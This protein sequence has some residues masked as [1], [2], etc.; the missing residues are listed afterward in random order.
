MNQTQLLVEPFFNETVCYR[1]AI[2][3][4]PKMNASNPSEAFLHTLDLFNGFGGFLLTTF[5]GT[6]RYISQGWN[7]TVELWSS[8]AMHEMTSSMSVKVTTEFYI[9]RQEN[10]SLTQGS[11]LCLRILKVQVQIS[12]NARGVVT[13][14][15]MTTNTVFEQYDEFPKMSL[16]TPPKNVK[17]IDF[18]KSSSAANG[19]AANGSGA[20]SDPWLS[21]L[22]VQHHQAKPKVA[23]R[24][25]QP[26][27]NVSEIARLNKANLGWSAGVNEVFQ[28][29]LA[30]LRDA[31]ALCG[32]VVLPGALSL[33]R[34]KARLI[35]SA[36]IP[37]SFD[38][39]AKWNHCPTI[40]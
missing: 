27:N 10:A 5:T 32:T 40:G 18:L 23:I 22:R 11:G 38:A 26:V 37:A 24:S 12:K 31:R 9:R 17:C 1:R 21:P 7:G 36:P 13:R 15:T 30:L 29:R 20:W 34:K 4:P 8:N 19:W 35:G 28:G 39:R 14:K 6:Q 25:T 33:R 16:F 3:L 2:E